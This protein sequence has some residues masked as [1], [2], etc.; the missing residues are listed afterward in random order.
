MRKLYNTLSE[1]DKRRFMAIESMVLGHGGDTYIANVLGC[2][3]KTV[4]RG[5]NEMENISSH[6]D[7]DRRIRRSGGG[8]KGYEETFPNIGKKFIDV[9]HNFTAGDP[10]SADIIWTNLTKQEIADRL[11]EKHGVSVSTL[12]VG[13]LLKKYNYR[14]RK[15]Q[16]SKSM[17]TV[18]NRN[19]Q[20]ENIARLKSEYQTKGSP[21]I[22]M[23]T[24]K[25]EDLGNYYREGRLYCKEVVQTWDHDF[26]SF[27]SGV[28]IPHGIFD[29][30]QNCGYI[31][32]GTS[33]DTSEFACDCLRNWWY[34]LGRRSYPD[35]TSILILCDG[36]GSNSS[37]HYI[38]KEDIQN[39][40]DEIGV[41][42]RIAHYPPY[43]SKYNPIEHR[44]FPH[45]TKACQGVVFKDV[46]TVK[47]LI[48]NT[49]TKTGLKVIVEV[50]DTIYKTGRKVSNGF[51]ENMKIKFDEYLPQ[52]N[53]SSVPQQTSNRTVI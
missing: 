15:A 43:T 53:Y 41:E 28:V 30:T 22:S 6:G 13:K 51:K 25:K 10:M 37:R 27:A 2:N 38:F 36:G 1:K 7:H 42:I 20:F 11:F 16:K 26:N 39:L 50:I 49:K 21:V 33:K 45:V 3:P 34:N 44:L 12:V 32:V 19:E 29:I 23:D 14:R 31:N 4:S 48:E 46:D 8:R 52:W 17:K 35:T 47:R 24:K 18:E 40:V 5:R 9:L